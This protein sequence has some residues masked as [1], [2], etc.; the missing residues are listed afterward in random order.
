MNNTG[1][2][3]TTKLRYFPSICFE[4]IKKM[5]FSDDIAKKRAV[6]GTILVLIYRT[7]FTQKQ[8]SQFISFI[9]ILYYYNLYIYLFIF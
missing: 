1:K 9:H 8:F 6:Y 5:Q 2:K 3:I 4:Q 7:A